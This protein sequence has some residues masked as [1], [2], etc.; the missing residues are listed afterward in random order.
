MLNLLIANISIGDYDQT[1]D[2]KKKYRTVLKP[3]SAAILI[4]N[5][6]NLLTL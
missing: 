4:F 6:W 1:G 2:L 5:Y 3:V